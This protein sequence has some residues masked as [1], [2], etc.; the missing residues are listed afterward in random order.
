MYDVIVVGGRCA[1]S[2]TGM[3]LARAGYRVLIVDRV[4]L[5]ADITCTHQLTVTSAARLE[6]WGLLDGLLATGSPVS[7]R[8]AVT[9]GA[10]TVHMRNPVVD[11]LNISLAPRRTLLDS[12]LLDAARDAGAEVREAFAVRDVVW[13]DGRVTGVVGY[14]PEGHAVCDVARMVVGAD[15]RHSLVARAV[16]AETYGR[17]PATACCYY[18]YWRG[19]GLTKPAW[20]LGEGASVGVIPTDDDLTCVVVRLPVSRW[21]RFK[22]EPEATYLAQVARFPAL[23]ERM[24]G[25]SRHGRFVGTAELG[26]LSRQPSGPGWALVGDAGRHTDPAGWAGIGD[27][28][29]QAELLAAALDDGLSGRVSLH[30]ALCRYHR[31]RDGGRPWPRRR[32]ACLAIAGAPPRPFGA[33]YPAFPHGVGDDVAA[34]AQRQPLGH[35]MDHGLYRAL[36][37]RELGGD[38]GGRPPSGDE[39]QHG[40]LPGRQLRRS[41]GGSH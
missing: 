31:H 39:A 14:G 1:G 20:W 4:S 10:S 15:G 3:L 7:D 27:A 25:A 36:R 40:L 41:T 12:V 24:A 8:M 23:A 32:P 38:L 22:R 30:E 13:R 11:G 37:V 21:A 35:A 6:R 9:V 5:P 34:V 17:Q 29:R 16:G 26:Q 28:F 19:S 18:A 2:A 33:S